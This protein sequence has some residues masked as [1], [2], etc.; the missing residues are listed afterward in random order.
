MTPKLALLLLS[1]FGATPAGEPWGLEQCDGSTRFIGTTMVPGLPA[2]AAEFQFAPDA[3][4]AERAVVRDWLVWANGCVKDHLCVSE[5]PLPCR[6]Q[7]CDGAEC[8]IAW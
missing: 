3:T 6:A 4:V 8:A 7:Q 2:S 1:M 5:P